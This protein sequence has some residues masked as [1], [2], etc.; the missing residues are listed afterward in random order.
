MLGQL[1][2]ARCIIYIYCLIILENFRNSFNIKEFYRILADMRR[3]D[4]QIEYYAV[5][6]SCILDRDWEYRRSLLSEIHKK[7]RKIPDK[8]RISSTSIALTDSYLSFCSG[9]L[10]AIENCL[11]EIPDKIYLYNFSKFR[12][13]FS[14]LFELAI[15]AEKDRDRD[16][17]IAHYSRIFESWMRL[18][19]DHSYDNWLD[20]EYIIER[21]VINLDAMG[22]TDESL[23][24]LS[25]F[26]ALPGPR[27]KNPSA[28]L[29][30]LRMRYEKL[31]IQ[32]P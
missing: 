28:R 13:S 31:K 3:T 6:I 23:I 24:Y 15:S 30:K 9:P 8:F 10:H 25:G 22:K 21:L 18:R 2:E 32:N 4:D 20:A 7:Q 1:I 5:A 14:N 11:K 17:A 26:F 19:Q 16:S 29:N 12:T 27:Q